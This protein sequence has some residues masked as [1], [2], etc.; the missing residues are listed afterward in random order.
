MFGR[1]EKSKLPGADALQPEGASSPS[2]VLAQNAMICCSVHLIRFIVCPY[3]AAAR[4][5]ASRRVLMGDVL[6]NLGVSWRKQEVFEKL[7]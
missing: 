2:L 7:Q 4:V 1:F 5:A 3:G 6:V